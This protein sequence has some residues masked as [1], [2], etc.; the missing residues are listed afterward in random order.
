MNALSFQTEISKVRPTSLR[1]TSQVFGSMRCRPGLFF[2]E[3]T[4]LVKCEW[5]GRSFVKPPSV[6]ARTRKGMYCS[7]NCR[8]L[9]WKARWREDFFSKTVLV[10]DC[11]VWKGCKTKFGYG[12][13]RLQ[14]KE[15][16][17]THRQAWILSFGAIPKGMCVLHKCDNP[18]CVNPAHL[19]LGDRRANAIDRHTKGRSYHPP[20]KTHCRCGHPLERRSYIIIER[21]RERIK[22]Y[23]AKCKICTRMTALRREEDAHDRPQEKV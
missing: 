9:G 8:L 20:R 2:L 5:C 22:I 6:V 23:N 18:P 10:G 14:G 15:R 3:R 17:D 19:F 1:A 4:M 13:Y 11:W 12:R 16:H 7:W 21:G